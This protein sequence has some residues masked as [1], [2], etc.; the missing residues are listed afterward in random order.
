MTAK[1]EKNAYSSLIALEVSRTPMQ[2]T[3]QN[4]P[5]GF[6]NIKLSKW[7]FYQ[8]GDWHDGIE[9]IFSVSITKPSLLTPKA[10]KLK[11][12]EEFDSCN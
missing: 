10:A 5:T 6:K 3:L 7:S 11:V 12:K 1:D 9:D 8:H 4:I 2:L